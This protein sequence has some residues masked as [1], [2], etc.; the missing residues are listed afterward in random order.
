MP[1]RQKK[2][3]L[4]LSVLSHPTIASPTSSRALTL[5]CSYCFTCSY[6]LTCSCSLTCSYSLTHSLLLSL[7][8]SYSHSLSGTGSASEHIKVAPLSNRMQQLLF[9]LDF[10][11]SVWR[12]CSPSLGFYDDNCWAT[13]AGALKYL[14][15]PSIKTVRTPTVQH[16]LGIT[17]IR[18]HQRK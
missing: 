18:I 5:T 15:R 10:N 17:R 4:N 13:A 8:Y 1:S 11:K 16:S 14:S 12:S 6:S 2:M 9:V 3:A 7:T